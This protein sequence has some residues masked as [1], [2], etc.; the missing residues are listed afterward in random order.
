MFLVLQK[1]R[2]VKITPLQDPTIRKISPYP[3]TLFGKLYIWLLGITG[4]LPCDQAYYYIWEAHNILIKAW[5]RYVIIAYRVILKTNLVF[6]PLFPT[7]HFPF[8]D[9]TPTLTTNI[10]F[11]KKWQT[12]IY[13]II[14]K[15][16]IFW[17]LSFFLKF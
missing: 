17:G 13:W 16:Y 14:L 15:W 7:L 2:L 8:F 12:M 4:M 11:T 5:E 6:Y 3:L 10:L 9:S 1:I